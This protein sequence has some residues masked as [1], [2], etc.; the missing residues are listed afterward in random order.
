MSRKYTGGR[1]HVAE[2]EE[3]GENFVLVVPASKTSRKEENVI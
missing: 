3:G 2:G 1:I